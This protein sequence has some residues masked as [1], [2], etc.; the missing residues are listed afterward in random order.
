M[1]CGAVGLLIAMN[2][3]IVRSKEGFHLVPKV[4]AKLEV[5]YY[6][7]RSFTIEDWQRRPSLAAAIVTSKNQGLMQSSGAEAVRA[8][9]EGLLRDWTGG[10]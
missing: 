1:V 4:A 7:I 10:P 9:V 3:Y 5:P 6:D 2:Y 8:K